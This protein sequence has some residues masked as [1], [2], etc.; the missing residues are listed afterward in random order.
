[1]GTSTLDQ[2]VLTDVIRDE[3]VASFMSPNGLGRMKVVPG[4][5]LVAKKGMAGLHTRR[6]TVAVGLGRMPLR[7]SASSVSTSEVSP[8]TVAISGEAAHFTAQ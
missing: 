2:Q 6:T 1:M 4:A 3:S 8:A 7:P 5:V